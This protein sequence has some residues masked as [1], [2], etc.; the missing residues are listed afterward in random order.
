MFANDGNTQDFIFSGLRQHFHKAVCLAVG[1]RPVKV[2]EDRRG[3][4]IATNY[5]YNAAERD[6]SMISYDGIEPINDVTVAATLTITA[7]AAGEVIEIDNGPLV[8]ADQTTQVRSTTATFE[9]VNFA[10]KTAVIVDGAGGGDTFSLLA[11]LATPGLTTLTLDGS[12]DASTFSITRTRVGT[13][14][15]ATGSASDDVFSVQGA[16]L[17]GALTLDGAGET[18]GDSVRSRGRPS[19]KCLP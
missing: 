1:N 8:G 10:N 2:I 7:T 18:A 13:A 9:L 12:T 11:S 6:G 17:A 19:S 16:N 14:T 4:L 3:H 5:L 15:F